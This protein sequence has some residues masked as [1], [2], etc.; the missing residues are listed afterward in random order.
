ML[1]DDRKGETPRTYNLDNCLIEKAEHDHVKT[2]F[3]PISLFMLNLNVHSFPLGSKRNT[4]QSVEIGIYMIVIF[5]N[6][7]KM[8]YPTRTVPCC[9]SSTRQKE[10]WVFSPADRAP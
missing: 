8:R 7:L 5:Q 4:G 2:V 3:V 10:K 9:F 6:R 1:A